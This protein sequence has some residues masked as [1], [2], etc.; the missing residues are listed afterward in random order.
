MKITKCT[1][2]FLALLIL[3]SNVGLAFNVHY[4]GGKIAGISSVYNVAHFETE[5]KAPAKKSCCAAKTDKDQSCCKD[6]VIKIDKKQEVVVKTF[7][8]QISLPFIF[9]AWQ[10]L[11]FIGTPLLQNTQ[12]PSYCFDANAPPL[13][14]L[15]SQYILYA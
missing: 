15:Y 14:Q 13:Y 8:F 9:E 2:L 12:I 1:S 5:K 7:S 3:V 11:V 4:C 10:P 6:K